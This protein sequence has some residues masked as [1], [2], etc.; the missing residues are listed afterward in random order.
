MR[1]RALALVSITSLALA[2]ASPCE[3]VQDSRDAFL[4]ALE[5]DARAGSAAHLSISL[6][7]DVVDQ[8]I[9]PELARVPTVAIPL[10]SVAG[11]SLGSLKLGVDQIRVQQ[12]PAGEVGFRIIVGLREGKTSVFTID[13]DARVRPEINPGEGTIVV[14][15]AGKDVIALEPSLSERSAKQLAKWIGNQLPDAARMLIDEDQ[16]AGF[17][18]QIGEQLLRQAAAAV[19][20]NLLD[21]LGE[22]ARF[23]FDLPPELPIA[24][25]LLSAG[26]RHLELDLITPLVVEHPLAAGHAR[27]EGLHPNLIQVR[28]AGD[29]AAA[30]ANHAIRSGKIPERWTLEGEPDPKGDILVAAGWAKGAS[31]P[32]EVHLWK[33][34]EDCAYVILRAKPTLQVKGDQLELGASQA[35]VEDVQ[36]SFKIRAGLFFSRTARKGISL[37][38]QTAA[39]T[40]VELAGETMQVSVH[41]AKVVGDELVLGLRLSKGKS[42]PR[43]K[44]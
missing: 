16:L 26:E 14:A 28:I 1:L 12:A 18:D 36:G 7:Y 38:E 2:C 6:P 35:K 5:S 42:K 31:D 27:V 15:L 13:I 4:A 24:R 10:P 19:K 23:E 29:A 17:A 21:D 30:L 44:R 33:L 43:P 39:T 20:K 40:E 41:D 3:R 37:V 25:V 11:M 8:L 34:V 22:L 32:L 9:A